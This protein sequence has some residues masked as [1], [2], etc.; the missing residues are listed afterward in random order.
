MTPV[1][2]PPT[3]S[4]LFRPRSAA[5]VLAIAV[6]VILALAPGWSP[7]ADPE[8][9]AEPGYTSL[10]DGTGTTGWSQAGPGGFTLAGGTLTS[11]GGLGMLW[12]S[13][14]EFRAYSLKMDWRLAG[15]DNSG[16]FIGFPASSDPWSAVNNGYEIQID[17]TDAADRTTG[18]VYGFKSADLPARD[19]ALR[20]PGEWNTYELLVEGE[21]LQLFLNGVKINDFTNTV[22]NR[23]L[24]QGHIGIQNHGNGDEASFRDIRIRELGGTGRTGEIRGIGG[25]C[26]DVS[27]SG[28]ADGTKIQLWTCNGTGAQRWTLPGDNTVRALGKCLDVRSSGTANGTITWLW[29]CNG[30]GAQQWVAQADGT[31]RNPPSGRCLD[32]S[33]ASSADGTQLH[34]WDCGTGANQKWVLP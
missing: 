32:A 22:P 13:A 26:V 30:S 2:V 17:A 7:A 4:T 19:A 20:P 3:T 5:L 15:D 8:A 12:Y 18:A 21:R 23:S 33:G 6:A 31:L 34:I 14:K 10:F 28:T 16:V 11:F 1:P 9:A 29:T 25:K 27:N 24:V